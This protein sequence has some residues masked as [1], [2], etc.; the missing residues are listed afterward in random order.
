MPTCLAALEAGDAQRLLL[1][2]QASA[3]IHELRAAGF[4]RFAVKPLTNLGFRLAL[5]E[6]KANARAEGFDPDDLEDEL[7][8]FQRSFEARILY[9]S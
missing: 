3:Y 7:R 9:R 6:V 1:L 8:V 2:D 5:R 4:Q